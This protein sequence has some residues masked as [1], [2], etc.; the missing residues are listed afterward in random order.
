MVTYMVALFLNFP[1][2]TKDSVNYE[3]T[4][5]KRGPLSKHLPKGG[6]FAGLKDYFA[7]SFQVKS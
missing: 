5:S 7:V 2:K 4:L 3:G 1:R 6:L